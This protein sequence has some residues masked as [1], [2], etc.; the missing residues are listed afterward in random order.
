MDNELEDSAV[1]LWD[2]SR[3]PFFFLFHSII[4]RSY[5]EYLFLDAVIYLSFMKYIFNPTKASCDIN[6]KMMDRGKNSL[7][8]RTFWGAQACALVHFLSFCCK[9]CVITYDVIWQHNSV[10][11]FSTEWYANTR[12]NSFACQ[13]R[14]RHWSVAEHAIIFPL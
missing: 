1:Q 5:Q 7:A 11:W 14:S 13:L 4:D 6:W 8:F 12:A 2:I 9:S 10:L 3:N